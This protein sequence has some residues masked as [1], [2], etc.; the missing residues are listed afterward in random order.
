MENNRCFDDALYAVSERIRT[1]LKGLPQTVKNNVEEIRLR[2]NMPIALTVSGD[3]VFVTR[4]ARVAFTFCDD[5]PRAGREDIT[6]TFKLLC[7]GSV[8]AHAREL[9]SGFVMMKNGCRAGVCG[10]VGENGVMRDITSVNIRIAHQ[11]IGC[12]NKVVR[13]YLGGGLLIAGPA[14]SGKTTLLRDFVRQLSS[15][16]M[17]KYRRVA[18]IDSRGEISGGGNGCYIN[19][20]GPN[21]D[22]I[23]TPEKAEGIEM[24]LRTMFPDVIA[25]DEIG[26][27]QELHKVQEC[28]FSGVE[29]VTTA[30]IGSVSELTK[31]RVTRELISLGAVSQVAVLSSLHG[32]E[33]KILSAKELCCVAV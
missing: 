30:H 28:F 23:F 14:G 21:T 17:G 10:T 5:L 16:V 13:A 19:D 11:V 3:T 4:T 12:A 29:I 22:L 32:S 27:T 26:T 25:F 15:S 20:L 31:R 9:K 7:A 8:Y 6:E 2:V 1:L 18:V 24:A 33:I